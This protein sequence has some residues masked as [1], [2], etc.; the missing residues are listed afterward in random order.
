MKAP[1]A[2]VDSRRAM[3]WV[4]ISPPPPA[5]HADLWGGRS[6]ATALVSAAR[7][8]KMLGH[9]GKELECLWVSCWDVQAVTSELSLSSP[10]MNHVKQANKLKSFPYALNNGPLSSITLKLIAV[11]VSPGMEIGVLG[12]ITEAR[13]SFPSPR[14]VHDAPLYPWTR[15]SLNL[16]SREDLVVVFA[17]GAPV[18]RA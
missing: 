18:C 10:G 13:L 11:H 2:P 14:R 5:S 8:Q 17:G 4:S 9:A 6:C 1:D 15:T 3:S 7:K 12:T 16:V